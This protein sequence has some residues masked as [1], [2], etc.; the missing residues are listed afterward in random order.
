M[1]KKITTI[2]L[3]VCI[4]TPNNNINAHIS[5]HTAEEIYS[6]LEYK[7]NI[8][9]DTLSKNIDI[10]SRCFNMCC[11]EK[12]PRGHR[13]KTGNTGPTG[14]IGVTGLT[15]NTG[16]T[17]ATGAGETGATG[18][19]G[20]TGPTGIAGT[21]GT[22]GNT[23]ATGLTGP[24]GATGAT[25]PVGLI[26]ATGN[27]GATG[28]TG[29]QGATGSIGIP[30]PQGPQGNTGA[31]GPQ[32]PTGS[33]GLPG[34]QGPQGTGATG[35]TGATGATGGCGIG[36]LILNPYTMLEQEGNFPGSV[37][38]TTVP[39]REF[40]GVYGGAY[41]APRFSAWTLPPSPTGIDFLTQ[42]F[43]GTQFVIPSDL[44]TTQPVFLDFH[45]L[46]E[47]FDETGDAQLQLQADYIGNGTELGNNA[48]ATGFAQT[49]LSGDFVIIE[50]VDEDNL[51]HI[52]VTVALN[53][54]LMV[55]NDW[56]FFLITRIN[57]DSE[58]EYDEDIYLSS[59]ALRYTRICTP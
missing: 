16:P 29:T 46:I 52:I 7:S 59:I 20:A 44:D 40:G 27:T 5:V 45:I 19:T 6:P 51:R 54:A 21:T 18:N 31:T 47:Q 28:A 38:T 56:G 9:C 30:G 14:A 12:C 25:G 17:G 26:G 34:P 2:L 1:I 11:P 55:D 22:T 35:N 43:I 15:G 23:G 57:P 4:T 39:D 37:S 13:G 42:H 50:P 24:T 3:F 32:G 48:P 36:C 58:N 33:Q 10:L 53:G 41:N 49:V 8:S